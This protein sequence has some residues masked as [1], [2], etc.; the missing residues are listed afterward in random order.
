[1]HRHAAELG[2]TPSVCSQGR[3][4]TAMADSPN[5]TYWQCEA[6]RLQYSP[7]CRVHVVLLQRQLSLFAPSVH[8]VGEHVLTFAWHTG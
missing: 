5:G 3:Y 4:G 8:V 2:V 6:A 1:M 7:V